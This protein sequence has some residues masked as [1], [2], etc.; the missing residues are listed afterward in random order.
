[1]V[2]GKILVPYNEEN[3]WIYE[4]WAKVAREIAESR[5]RE[6]QVNRND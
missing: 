5:A 4:T 1:M 2:D 6:L 3:K